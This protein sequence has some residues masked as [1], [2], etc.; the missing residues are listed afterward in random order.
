MG[1]EVSVEKW[2]VE[3]EETVLLMDPEGGPWESPLMELE[4]GVR[5]DPLVG[6]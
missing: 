2:L 4:G 5:G 6:S 3:S 1:V